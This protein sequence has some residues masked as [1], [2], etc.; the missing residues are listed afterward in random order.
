MVPEWFLQVLLVAVSIIGGGAVWYFLSQKELHKTLWVGFVGA[1]L[2]LLVLALYLR[3][4]IVRK[5]TG[6]RTPVYFGE[7][8][9]GNEPSPPLPSASP[10]NTVQLL[11]GD[12]LRVL[13][14]NAENYVFSR[15][16]KSFLSVGVRNGLMRISAT[17]MDSSNRYIVRIIDNEFKANP[18]HAFNPRQAD[19]HSLVVRDGEGNEVLNIR[20]LNPRAMRIVGRFHLPGYS[21]PVLILP[22]EGI[23][24]PGGG[25]ISHL[26]VDL[27]GGNAGFIGF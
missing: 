24:W 19:K 20:F 18:E 5:E 27:T 7:L 1:T 26:T 10:S 9:P 15:G 22:L 16:G 3:N 13:S 14:A 12:D 17:V 23:H 8:I 21:E 6:A 2:L 25:G 11:L 4:E